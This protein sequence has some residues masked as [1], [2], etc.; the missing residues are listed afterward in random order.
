MDV[1]SRLKTGTDDS[2]TKDYS[3]GWMVAITEVN[4]SPHQDSPCN[5][6]CN[7]IKFIHLNLLCSHGSV[8]NSSKSSVNQFK[9][10]IGERPMF[11]IGSVFDLFK[12]L[13]THCD[14]YSREHGWHLLKCSTESHLVQGPILQVKEC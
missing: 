5:P 11:L 6:I 14:A 7:I 3:E 9:N 8:V 10:H 13:F 2:T 12:S 1:N 4:R